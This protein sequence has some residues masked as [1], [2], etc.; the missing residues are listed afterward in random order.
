M[1]AL[2]C[3]ALLATLST[4]AGFTDNLPEALK[5]AQEHDRSVFM[6]CS[7]SDWCG[8]CRRLEQEVLSSQVFLDNMTNEYELVY[9]DMPNDK[10]L[11]SDW[12]KKHNEEVCE[13]YGVRGFPSC[14]ILDK[15]GKIVSR[16]GYE[17]GGADKYS[18]TV[19]Y[20]KDNQADID[21]YIMPVVKKVNTLIDTM[22]KMGTFGGKE[23]VRKFCRPKLEKLIKDVETLELPENIAEE[24]GKLL[25]FL[26]DLLAQMEE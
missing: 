11:L 12:G 9:I 1:A 20:L 19:K 4:P 14:F 5:S 21:K 10:S 17:E 16:M 13:K 2:I 15:D 6:V 26:K 8:W 18:K 24:K 23:K 7:G 25:E 3:A 22:N